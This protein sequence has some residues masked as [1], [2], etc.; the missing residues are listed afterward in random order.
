MNCGLP[1]QIL[2]LCTWKERMEP[3]TMLRPVKRSIAAQKSSRKRSMPG[4]QME[5]NPAKISGVATGNKL[6]GIKSA[7]MVKNRA[8]V[9]E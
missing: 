3:V 4:F 9:A 5:L 8:T 1:D 7:A 6:D 2:F